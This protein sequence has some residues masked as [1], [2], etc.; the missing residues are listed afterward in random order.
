MVRRVRCKR[1]IPGPGQSRGGG[2]HHQGKGMP[3]FDQLLFLAYGA[4]LLLVW[5]PFPCSGRPATG[6][7]WPEIN[8]QVN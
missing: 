6:L 5:T 7:I 8:C 1:P 2:I 3:W 4:L